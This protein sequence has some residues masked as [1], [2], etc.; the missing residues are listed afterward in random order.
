MFKFVKVGVSA[1]SNIHSVRN[2]W[3]ITFVQYTTN[4]EYL[5]PIPCGENVQI[6]SEHENIVICSEEPGN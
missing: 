5:W 2:W 3:H 4:S 6:Q 1:A